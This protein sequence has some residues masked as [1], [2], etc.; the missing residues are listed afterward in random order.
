MCL[1][2]TPDLLVRYCKRT[3]LL[4]PN[5]RF[6]GYKNYLPAKVEG[7]AKQMFILIQQ[8]I[9]NVTVAWI[10]GE[11][12]GGGYPLHASEHPAHVQ[13]HA[14]PGVSLVQSGVYYSP[15]LEFMAFEIG[16]QTT[17]N[18]QRGLKG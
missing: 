4:D 17:T 10:F 2:V 1:L 12:L 15:E 9:P 6:F 18:P 14:A 11:L 8:R 3:D 16:V 5:D 7:K 13:L